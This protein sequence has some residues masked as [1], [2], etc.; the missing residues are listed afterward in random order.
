MDQANSCPI[1]VDSRSTA[2]KAFCIVVLSSICATAKKRAARAAPLPR[3]APASGLLAALAE[4]AVGG[5]LV[6]DVVVALPLGC[7]LG[8]GLLRVQ[9]LLEDGVFLGLGG[10][11]LVPGVELRLQDGVRR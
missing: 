11:H 3:W 8:E 6:V 9:H 2:S 10:D 5:H 4:V 7:T 1:H